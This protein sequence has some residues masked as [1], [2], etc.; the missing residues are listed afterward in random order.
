MYTCVCKDTDDLF[1]EWVKFDEDEF[2]SLMARAER[3]ISAAEP[4]LRISHDPSWYECRLCSYHAFCHGA[5]VP[6]P[7]CRTCAHS[8]AVIAGDSGEWRCEKA[9]QAGFHSRIDLARQRVGCSGHRFIP[10]LL[11]KVGDQV[12]VVDDDV[13]YVTRSGDKFLNGEAPGALSSCEL[14]AMEDCQAAALAG[15]EKLSLQ[16]AGIECK[17]I[18]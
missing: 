9:A 15:A 3:I 10:V 11:E 7:N 12:D 18:G 1:T 14:Y 6:E 2:S 16:K 17:V 5:L 13:V 8:T 4:P